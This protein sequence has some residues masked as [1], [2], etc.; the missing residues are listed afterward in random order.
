MDAKSEQINLFLKVL[1]GYLTEFNTQER[2]TIVNE[3]RQNLTDMASKYPD[4]SV[5]KII[6][7][8]GGPKV[9]ANRYL[10]EA[11]KKLHP[12]HLS[13]G[14]GVFLAGGIMAASFALLFIY[15]VYRFTPLVLV[16]QDRIQLLG[17][18]IDIDNRLGSFK[19]GTDFEFRDADY[20]NIFDGSIDIGED[21]ED[22]SLNF[23]RGQIEIAMSADERFSWNCKLEQE[24]NDQ[25][26][27]N[28]KESLSVNLSQ[29][30][31]AQCNLKIPSRL[32][33]TLTGQSGKVDL[34]DPANDSYIQLT[35][36]LIALSFNPELKY[37]VETQVS[38]GSVDPAFKNLKDEGGIEIKVDLQ[39][40]RIQ[41]R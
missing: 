35:N 13:I 10:A 25:F 19:M 22:L 40:G 39:N 12:N 31:G 21:V 24:P 33:I 38:N 16:K 11:G 8:L 2:H 32:K 15:A 4:W 9:I 34:V 29:F 23:D 36:G 41:K 3:S 1:E 27:K 20:E 7:A 17:G 5:K 6:H 30:G 18:I 14:Q 26:L 28:E 37:R